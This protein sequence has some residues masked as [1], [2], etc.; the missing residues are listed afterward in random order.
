MEPLIPL[1]TLI[2]AG[3]PHGSKDFIMTN[4]WNGLNSGVWFAKNGLWAEGFLQLAWEQKH[5]IPAR[6]DAKGHPKHPFE[7][8]QRAFHYL[9]DSDVWKARGLPRYRGAGVITG[10]QT[11]SKLRSKLNIP[12]SAPSSTLSLSLSSHSPQTRHWQLSGEHERALLSCA[13]TVLHEFLLHPP[14]RHRPPQRK[15]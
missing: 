8:E 2:A 10:S 6:S 11:D 3:N 15:E 14:S 1:Q 12:L 13:A 4:D 9:L 5:L 7:Y